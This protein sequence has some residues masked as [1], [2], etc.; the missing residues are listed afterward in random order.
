MFVNFLKNKLKNTNNIKNIKLSKNCKSANSSNLENGS[1]RQTQI[2]K[3]LCVQFLKKKAAWNKRKDKTMT[4]ETQVNLAKSGK[5]SF[6]ILRVW[7]EE[8]EYGKGVF[9]SEYSDDKN[10]TS[11]KMP[12]AYSCRIAFFLVFPLFLQSFI[13][14]FRLWDKTAPEYLW[15]K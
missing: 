6:Y 12:T 11:N 15:Y 7:L 3:E 2:W 1:Q 8:Y 14:S 5:R 4:L 10:Y 13:A 9:Y